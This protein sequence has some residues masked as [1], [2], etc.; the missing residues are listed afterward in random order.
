MLAFGYS[1]INDTKKIINLYDI[2]PKYLKD[3][4]K[5]ELPKKLNILD[6]KTYIQ[7]KLIVYVEDEYYQI[8]Q[9]AWLK[10]NGIECN[11]DNFQ[12]L[13][14]DKAPFA[15]K[16]GK[17]AGGVSGLL[18]TKD[19]T[20]FENQKIVGV[21][22]FDKE[23][24]E[25]IHNLKRETFWEEDFEGSKQ[26]GLYK[27]RTDCNCMFALLLPI[28][29]R[30]EHLASLEWDNFVSYVEIENLLPEDFLIENHFVKNK[31]YPGGSYLKVKP[32]VKNRLWK[33]LFNL[34]KDEF[35]DFKPLFET[36][37]NLF[38]EGL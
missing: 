35:I 11:K 36:I 28:P 18:R 29:D 38:N 20:L 9:I 1:Q 2:A 16:T 10:L 22:D 34:K 24:R 12:S 19:I 14:E 26:Q 13:F 3:S 5:K 31:T 23:G 21:F 7:H 37:M 25:N 30:L 6:S 32:N 33:S 8:Y 15:I 4:I 27:K 17:S